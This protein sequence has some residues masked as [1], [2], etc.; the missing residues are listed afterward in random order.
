MP[1]IRKLLKGEFFNASTVIPSGPSGL[2]MAAEPPN[3]API[4]T[5]KCKANNKRYTVFISIPPTDTT[6]LYN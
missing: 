3:I 1:G 2:I 4:P 5:N 6:Y